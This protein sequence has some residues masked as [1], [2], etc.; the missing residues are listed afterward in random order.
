MTA[1][2]NP[3]LTSDWERRE[4]ETQQ[5]SYLPYTLTSCLPLPF[6]PCLGFEPASSQGS[7]GENGTTAW[8]L[9]Q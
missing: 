4:K 6:Q 3:M 8:S 1:N 9:K 2:R 5:H 7:A